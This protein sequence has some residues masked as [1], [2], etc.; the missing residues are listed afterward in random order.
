MQFN[1]IAFIDLT[2]LNDW[3]VEQLQAFSQE[4]I[5]PPNTFPQSEEEIIRR[6]GDAECALVS[7]KTQVNQKVIAACPKLQYIGMCCSLYDEKSANVD[8]AF[9]R[10]KGITVKAVRDYGDEGLVEYIISELLQLTKGIGP[11]QWK[12]DPVELTHRKLGIIGL[13]V[14]GQM[15]ADRLK[16]FNMD[17]YYYS[18]TRKPKA[19]LAGIQYLTLP[20]LLEKVEI[21]SIHLP[22]HSSILGMKEFDTFGNR[23]ILINTSI[24]LTFE[25][26][27]F[28]E[29]VQKE[30]N[31][32]IMDG[33][34]IRPYEEEL[35]SYPSILATKVVSGWTTEAKHRL[36][37]KVVTTLKE[38]VRAKEDNKNKL[39]P[40][41][42]V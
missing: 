1:K 35:M 16:A 24:G 23:K 21:I 15:L 20:D 6:I 4:K 34:G 10:K 14:T 31:Y 22:K 8:I 33:C 40:L 11:H 37:Q 29:W 5:V 9:A 7:W 3:A 39:S 42:S 2:G 25:K 13:G 41:P 32:A 30:G 12:K 19:E 28:L 38:F 26:E 18:R 17:L 36:S 27:P